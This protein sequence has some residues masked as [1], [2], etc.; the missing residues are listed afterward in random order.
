VRKKIVLSVL[1]MTAAWLVVSA[2]P[3]TAAPSHP[4]T[5]A[6]QAQPLIWMW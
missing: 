3:A 5:S 6:V 1:G 2:A 4:A